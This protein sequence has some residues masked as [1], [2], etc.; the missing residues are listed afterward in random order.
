M[1]EKNL[2]ENNSDKEKFIVR[3]DRFQR[4]LDK[5][6]Y[7]LYNLSSYSLKLEKHVIG[8]YN[9]VIDFDSQINGKQFLCICIL[10]TMKT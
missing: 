4:L 1:H 6:C 8:F 3:I 7:F 5:D 2:I 9:S 10:D